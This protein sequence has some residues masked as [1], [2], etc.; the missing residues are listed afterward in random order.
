MIVGRIQCMSLLLAAQ[1]T[2]MIG[3]GKRIDNV[4]KSIQTQL[5]RQM[6]NGFWVPFYWLGN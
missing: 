5:I 4:L 1:H 6:L 3:K 2:V